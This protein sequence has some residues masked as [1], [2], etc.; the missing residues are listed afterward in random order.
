MGKA[1]SSLSEVVKKLF[2]REALVVDEI[3]PEGRRLWTLLDCLGQPI[4]SMSHRSWGLM[5]VE[6]QT[7]VM[8]PIILLSLPGKAYTGVLEKL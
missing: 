7:R 8:V 1:S 3:C 5:L 4:S 2:D 6:G